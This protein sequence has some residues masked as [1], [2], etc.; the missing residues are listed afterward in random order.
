MDHEIMVRAMGK[1][2]PGVI[3]MN[4]G[5]TC[6]IYISA[7]GDLILSTGTIEAKPGEIVADVHVKVLLATSLDDI[8]A[9]F[10]QGV[11]TGTRID[12][13]FEGEPSKT[14]QA[15]WLGSL[16]PDSQGFYGAMPP[17]DI[18]SKYEELRVRRN[19]K[20]T[21]ATKESNPSYW[22]PAWD[23][24]PN[25]DRKK[26]KV[27]RFDYFGHAHASGFI[28][29]YGWLNQK[30]ELPGFDVEADLAATESWFDH[31]PTS[32]TAKAFL[33]GCHLGDA[34]VED[35]IAPW[36]ARQ[37]HFLEVIAA[38]SQTTY[39]D[40]TSVGAMPRPTGSWVAFPSRA[41]R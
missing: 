39:R 5:A 2:E 13:P 8:Y 10:S 12:A 21:P 29:Q 22:N 3:R 19:F 34:D 25:V 38:D 18:A 40:S 41:P 33:W 32:A 4:K 6:E 15:K 23:A 14:S 24:A 28:L 17:S 35:A 16:G 11:W 9:Y 27:E 30:G 7:L 31:H 36:W 26:V 20:V 37:K 1:N